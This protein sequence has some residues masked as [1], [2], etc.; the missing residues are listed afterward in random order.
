LLDSKK[1]VDRF[2]TIVTSSHPHFS[3][4]RDAARPL[5]PPPTITA[6]LLGL[7]VTALSNEA[8]LIPVDILRAKPRRRMAP[9]TKMTEVFFAALLIEFFMMDAASI[10]IK[11]VNNMMAE[12]GARQ[13]S[14][15]GASK[16]PH[17]NYQ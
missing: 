6:D 15:C 13:S 8:D 12:E 10:P 9:E 7:I 4:N 3:S 1:F 2:S 14:R 5:G 17:N 16:C 11:S